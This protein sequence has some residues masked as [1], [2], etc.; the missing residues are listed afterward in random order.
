EH[1]QTVVDMPHRSAPRAFV[2]ADD[3]TVFE[4]HIA[5][6]KPSV[7]AINRHEAE[8]SAGSKSLGHDRIVAL[9]VGIPVEHEEPLRPDHRLR[10]AQ[11]TAGSEQCRPIVCV[12]YPQAEPAAVA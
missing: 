9:K 4:L 6:I 11:C 5:G 10:A 1:A 2:V 7:I 12:T 3:R 8:A